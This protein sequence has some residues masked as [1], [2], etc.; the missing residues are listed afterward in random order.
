[1]AT[2]HGS[3]ILMNHDPEEQRSNVYM[4]EYLPETTAT[5]QHHEN[6]SDHA[7]RLN[8][9]DLKAQIDPQKC[10]V[11]HLNMKGAPH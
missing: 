2:M 5:E 6:I 11:K 8:V 10:K 7:V 9:H 3:Y 4:Q 1:M